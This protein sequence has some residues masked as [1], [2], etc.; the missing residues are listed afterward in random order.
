MTSWQDS[1]QPINTTQPPSVNSWQASFQPIN[2]PSK[3]PYNINDYK[4]DVG[5]AF[6]SGVQNLKDLGNANTYTKFADEFSNPTG[7]YSGKLQSDIIQG[8]Y[9]TAIKDAFGRMNEAAAMSPAGKLLGGIFGTLTSPVAPAINAGVDKLDQMGIPKEVTQFALNNSPLILKGAKVESTPETETPVNPAYLTAANELVNKQGLTP[10]TIMSAAS[11]IK[12]FG[13]DEETPNNIPATLPEMLQNNNLLARQRSYGEQANQAGND[14]QKFNAQRLN[15]TLPAV[16]ENLINQAG[17]S[18]SSTL[19]DAGNQLQDVVRG[20]IDKTVKE[21]TDSVKPLYDSIKNNTVSEPDLLSLRSNPLI[22]SEYQK[23]LKN[24]ALMERQN[25]FNPK[26]PDELKNLAPEAQQQALSQLGKQPLEKTTV[27]G[28][29]PDSI[30]AVDAV[31]KN[32][33]AQIDAMQAQGRTQEKLYSLLNQAKNQVNDTLIEADPRYKI[34]NDEYAS[35]SPEIA[36]MKKGAL[37]KLA[38]AQNGENAANTF[39]NM[40][41]EELQKI[42]PKI[43]EVNPQAI[44]SIASAI[45]RDIVDKTSGSGISPFLKAISGNKLIQDKMQALLSPDAYEAQQA[46]ADTLKKVQLGLPRNSETVSKALLEQQTQEEA[47]GMGLLEKAQNLPKSKL[48]LFHKGVDLANK[49]TSKFAQQYKADMI[50]L[51]TDPDLDELGKALEQIKNPKARTEAVL[52]WL[53]NKAYNAAK[54]TTPALQGATADKRQKTETKATFTPMSQVT[55]EPFNPV[56]AEAFKKAGINPEAQDFFNKVAKAE[57]NNNPNAKNA[58]TSASGKYQFTDGTWKQMVKRYGTDTGITDADK[59]DPK[60]QE[61]M[62][63]LFAKDNITRMQPFLQR[64]PTKGE[65]Y[66]AHVL[67]ADG[68]LRLINAANNDPNKQ[69]IMLFPKAVTM[70]NKSI[71]FN[72]NTPRTALEVYQTL[73]KKVS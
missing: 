55:T 17:D 13:K 43:Q 64:L 29:A 30:A 34:A 60:A 41:R 66:S 39:K 10:E 12:D 58:N 49:Y 16:K 22:E 27:G 59:N 48:D 56:M 57:S 4:Q 24:D 51:F 28:L 69:A 63:K 73:V 21:R 2:Q 50:K 6:Q 46:L 37:G 19:T 1:F 32:I 18:T 25:Q 15:E 42:V 70:A 72:G 26:I 23:V 44:N 8:N 38:R 36:E 53:G 54:I 35:Q 61:T 33:A 31:K 47:N 45:L 20:I 67:G 68:A 40:S 62:V 5:Q 71:F 7:E 9:G 11:Q 14:F 3:D 52:Q 65:L